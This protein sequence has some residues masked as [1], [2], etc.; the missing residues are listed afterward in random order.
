MEVGGDKDEMKIRGRVHISKKTRGKVRHVV[1]EKIPL[2]LMIVFQST[3]RP[4]S[5]QKD[6]IVEY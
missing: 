5:N 1:T 3:S 2:T 6:M 4:L